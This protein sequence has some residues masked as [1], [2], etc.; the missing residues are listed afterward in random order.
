M[1]PSDQPSGCGI[2][3]DGEDLGA[4]RYHMLVVLLRESGVDEGE[5]SAIDV[6]LGAYII[7]HLCPL[8]SEIFP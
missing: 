6:L 8:V 5:M 1:R 7:F 4:E 2:L 3:G